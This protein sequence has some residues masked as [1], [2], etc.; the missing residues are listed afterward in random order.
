MSFLFPPGL[1]PTGGWPGAVLTVEDSDMVV[2]ERVLLK[3]NL[4]L[5]SKCLYDGI[6]VSVRKHAQLW[7]VKTRG[8][9]NTNGS[10]PLDTRPGRRMSLPEGWGST[11][12]EDL[13][14]PDSSTGGG[15]A[16]G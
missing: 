6:S 4:L 11:G 14:A 8:E 7:V 1:M 3:M 5:G 2:T 9:V 15:G 16:H 10:A 12:P 13:A